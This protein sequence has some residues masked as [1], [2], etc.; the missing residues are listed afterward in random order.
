[1]QIYMQLSCINWVSFSH[2]LN[3]ILKSNSPSE[4]GNIDIS[5]H[6]KCS[7]CLLINLKAQRHHFSQGTIWGN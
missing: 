5:H 3:S 7:A 6:R 4:E 2:S 1:M